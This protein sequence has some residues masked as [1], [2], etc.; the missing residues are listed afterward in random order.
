MTQGQ[1]TTIAGI[2]EVCIGIPDPIFA[3][4]YWEQFGYRIGQVGELPADHAYQLYG[5][6]SSLRSI[7]LYHQN[8]DHGLI[9]LMVWQKPTNQG[10]GLAS[11]KIK[12]NRWATTLTADILTIL[13]H[14]EDAK[15]QGW[16]IKYTNP[17]WEVIYNK[18]RKSRPFTDPRVGVREML[19]LQPLTRQILFQRFGYTITDYGQINYGAAF[20]TSQCTHM[21]IIV[22]DDTKEILKFYEEVLGLLRVRDDVETTYE[23]SQAAGEIFDLQPGEKFI[24]TAFD[25]PRSAKNHLMAARSGRLYIVRFPEAINLESR[26]EAS[27][28][29]CFGI[30]LYTYRIRDI[31][32]Y[33][34]RIK[35]S[36][37]LKYTSI[38][39]NEFR[40]KS[41]SFVAPD[42]YFWNLVQSNEFSLNPE[43][44]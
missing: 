39:E 14:A 23:S 2:Y 28:P 30:S 27:Q 1:Q 18:E 17:Q 9:R 10:L 31:Q 25:D 3:I 38:I 6:N 26:F 34:H 16:A 24:V 19:L 20:Q 43:S 22:Q 13:N 44:K 11:M 8:A 7:R 37:V 33:C 4:Q 5:V 21:G 42:G 40:E 36:S 15:A 35:A 12:G 41:F 32:Q 29:G